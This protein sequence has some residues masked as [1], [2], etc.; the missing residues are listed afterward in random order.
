MVENPPRSQRPTALT[1]F[2]DDFNQLLNRKMRGWPFGWPELPRQG[3]PR[4]LRTFEHLPS[5]EVK[6]NDK[7][8]VVTV[9]PPGLD[10]AANAPVEGKEIEIKP[11]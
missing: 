1:P 11:F 6:E 8:Y 2:G 3:E 10:E 5:V 9:E 7:S 4:A